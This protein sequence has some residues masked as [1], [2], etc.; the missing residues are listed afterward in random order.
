MSLHSSLKTSGAL[1]STRNVLTRTERIA[2]LEKTKGYSVD[3]KPALGLPK[4]KAR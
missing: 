3:K 2:K 4:T 1:A